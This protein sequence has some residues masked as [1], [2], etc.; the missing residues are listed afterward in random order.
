MCMHVCVHTYVKWLSEDNF[1]AA[2]LLLPC[3]SQGLN[4]GSVSKTFTCWAVSRPAS[5]LPQTRL[6]NPVLKWAMSSTSPVPR[7]LVTWSSIILTSISLR[8]PLLFTAPPIRLFLKLCFTLNVGCFVPCVCAPHAGSAWA[9]QKRASD[10]LKL[11][12]QSLVSCPVGTWN[13][14]P[15]E[16]Q[17]VRS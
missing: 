1:G 10:H 11:E 6:C 5:D 7:F 3:G 12:L 2:S 13:L 16:G 9:G 14:D 8:F 15:P 4:S 17:P